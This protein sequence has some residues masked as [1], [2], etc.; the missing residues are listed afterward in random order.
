MAKVILHIG[1][2]KTGTTYLQNMF[3]LNRDRLAEDGIHYPDIGP[4]TAHHALAAIWQ[5]MPD[6]PDSF[7]GTQG[8]EGL[9]R[10]LIDTYAT[11]PGTLFLSA[12][13]FSRFYPETVDMA[14]LAARLSV[15][16]D[17]KIVYTMRTQPELVQSLWLQLA[18]SGKPLTIYPFVRNTLEHR[19]SFGI[20]IDHNAV[21]DTLLQ[22]F[23]PDQ[24]HL[25]DY[26]QIRRSP[27]GVVQSFLTLLG[28]TLKLDDL[29]Q[30][31][32][33]EANISPN[34]LAYW[35]AC[36]INSGN[37]PDN[38]LVQRVA[39]VLSQ[40]G[41]PNSLLARHEYHKLAS[42]YAPANATLI[43]RVQP[44]QPSFTFIEPKIPK[45]M[46]Y[47]EEVSQKQWSDIAAQAYILPHREAKLP[48]TLSRIR[49]TLTKLRPRA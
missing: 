28:S 18:R 37:T 27:G 39:E 7:F 47:R 46:L 32:R 13:N 15:F 34:P 43:E 41:S 5:K 24:I 26:N 36:Q 8:P 48:E 49:Q 6:V 23:M 21:Y 45:N 17:I 22:G 42:R 19:R 20:R 3:H 25:L 12:E 16:S 35:I 40:G 30:P 38:L 11:A 29:K 31:S 1:A 10:K 9:W 2:H 4:N 14:D 44:W 33:E